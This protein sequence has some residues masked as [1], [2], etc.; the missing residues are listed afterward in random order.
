MERYDTTV[1]TLDLQIQQKKS[2]TLESIRPLI[3]AIRV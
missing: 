1:A 3:N 2:R